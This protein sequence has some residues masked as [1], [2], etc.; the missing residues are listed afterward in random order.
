MSNLKKLLRYDWPLH[1]VLLFTN[2]LPDNIQILRLRGYLASP[3]FRK[4]GKNLRL[5][6]NITFYNPSRISIGNDVYIALGNWF[7]AAEAID[8]DDQVIIGP[9]NVFVTGDHTL[10]DGSFRYGAHVVAPIKIGR[11]SWVASS[12]TITKGSTIGSGSVVGANSMVNKD[13]PS[14][15]MAGGCPA[16]PIKSLKK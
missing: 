12:C 16:K 8:I 15:T 9:Y 4:C 6:R 3:F 1:F 13:I 7:M 11:G 10:Q 14:D 5:G 2:W